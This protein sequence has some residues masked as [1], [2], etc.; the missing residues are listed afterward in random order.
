MLAPNW[1]R[2]GRSVVAN[3][4][5]LDRSMP[6]RAIGY[7]AR[8]SEVYVRFKDGAKQWVSVFQVKPQS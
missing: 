4:V 2:R 1:Y 5:D 7:D 3:R 6:G 8:K